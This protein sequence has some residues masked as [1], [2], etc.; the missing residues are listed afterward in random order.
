MK[1]IRRISLVISGFFIAFLMGSA[2]FAGN[3]PSYGISAAV[4]LPLKDEAPL[5][6]VL[7]DKGHSNSHMGDY[8][9]FAGD[10]NKWSSNL[11][12]W[13]YEVRFLTGAIHPENLTDVDIFVGAYSSY[14]TSAG[15]TAAE[16]AA[17]KAWFD[18]GNKSVWISGD[19]DFADTNGDTAR[20]CNEI[21]LDLGSQA[22]VE[23][24]SVES[25]DNLGAAYR[26]MASVYNLFDPLPNQLLST[27]KYGRAE[28]HGP[29][30]VIGYNYSAAA[31]G[32][33]LSERLVKLES[34]AAKAYFRARNLYW[35]ISATN[36]ATHSS[37]LVY[38]TPE[39]N[40]S[41]H[42][43]NEQTT[44]VMM[45]AEENAGANSSSKIVV[46][47][48][49]PWTTY[50]AMFNDPGEHGYLQDQY[51]IVREVFNWFATPGYEATC[52]AHIISPQNGSSTEFLEARFEG[53][54]KGDT[55]A[56]IEVYIDGS[57]KA[58]LTHSY[59]KYQMDA[60]VGEHNLTII[61]KS[62]EGIVS[63]PATSIFTV[64][65]EAPPSV[66]T[67]GDISYVVG[68]TGNII[69]WTPSD[70]FPES[71]TI[72]QNGTSV[73]S[74]SWDGSYIEISIDGLA[75]GTYNYTLVIIDGGG[76]SASD[77]VIVTVTTEAEESSEEDDEAIPGFAVLAG[78]AAI[79]LPAFLTTR[80]RRRS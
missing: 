59:V 71:Y 66:N 73:D 13:G 48:E 7:I 23:K 28:F 77:T 61:A 44:F 62:V 75:L 63:D 76:N 55:I 37:T 56:F 53:I 54:A 39:S 67:P 43:D 21:L 41:I 17:L 51:Y 65:D 15:T 36:N 78:L 72:Y 74:G 34:S 35:V 46:T 12:E 60:D 49:T 38:N 25:E 3:S 58:N 79:G 31:D 18:T 64:V 22:L 69:N 1:P 68:S 11:T 27:A 33:P 5:P 10:Y 52:Q 24:A 14:Y 70:D 47:G 9:A 26:V 80:R 16:R 45:T 29:A 30:P 6:V 20:I 40:F 19:S 8:G 57:F 42:D 50:K 32:R 2:F 4:A